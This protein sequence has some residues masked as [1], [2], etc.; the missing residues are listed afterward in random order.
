[1]T[2]TTEP[3]LERWIAEIT[4]HFVRRG[5]PPIM[6]R[7]LAW[8]MVCDP[9]E[10]S[11]AQISAA[12]QASRAS[13]TSTLRVLTTAGLVRSATRP[14]DRTTYYRVADDAWANSWRQQ[15]A[16]LQAF[17][18]LA[19]EGMEILGADSPRAARVRG[20]HELYSFLIDQA[21]PLWKQW[22]DRKGQS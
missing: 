13:L 11:P 6:A 16:D 3:G 10:Q 18:T 7:T 17:A 14:G 2:E 19:R 22:E 20:A 12:V 1:M 4:D 8:L 9:P 21:E 5:W 15:L